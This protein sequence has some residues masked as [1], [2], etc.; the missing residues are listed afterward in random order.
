MS[1]LRP[2]PRALGRSAALAAAY[3]LAA[4]LGLTMS[5]VHGTISPVWPPTG[6][7][8]AS[9]AL[10]GI[11]LWPA[12]AIGAFAANLGIAGH[13][14]SVAAWIAVGN[15]LEALLGGWL[16]RRFDAAREP[17][18]TRDAVVVVAV[19][20]AA[21][22]PSATGGVLTLSLAGFAGWSEL[23]AA[24]LVWWMPSVRWWWRR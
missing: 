5:L 23:P 2:M 21:P 11:R 22:L 7:A 9:L 4:W 13:A 1:G 10:W 14:P 15:T 8:V 17:T 18:T 6:L 20:A 3:L 16:L 19:A 12:V 24:W